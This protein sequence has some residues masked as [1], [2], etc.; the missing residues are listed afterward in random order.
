VV[1]RNFQRETDHETNIGISLQ[2]Y[3]NGVLLAGN[4]NRVAGLTGTAMLSVHRIV[5]PPC[6]G[7]GA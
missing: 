4:A 1:P 5:I 3:Y 2:A 7:G 6:E